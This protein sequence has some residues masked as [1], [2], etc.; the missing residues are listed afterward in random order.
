MLDDNGLENIHQYLLMRNL[1][2]YSFVFIIKFIKNL[3]D[4]YFDKRKESHR[5]EEP[6]EPK[7]HLIND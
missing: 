4:S 5:Y 6:N 3:F 2:P 7:E 1:L